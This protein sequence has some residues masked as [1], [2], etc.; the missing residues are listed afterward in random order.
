MTNFIGN[1]LPSNPIDPFLQGNVLQLIV[2]AVLFAC[3]IKLAGK[4][5]QPVIDFFLALNQVVHQLT[6]LVIRFAPFGVF[7]LIALAV[8]TFG[9]GVMTPLLTLVGTVYAGCAALL[10][11][12]YP[13]GLYLLDEAIGVLSSHYSRAFICV[14]F[15]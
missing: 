5:A 2:F 3:A 7:A 9:L 13:L 6:S 12:V 8:G 14:Y 15:F 1:L 4:T 10:L 11:V